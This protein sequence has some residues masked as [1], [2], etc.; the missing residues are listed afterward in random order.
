MCLLNND[1]NEK[2][3]IFQGTATMMVTPFADGRLWDEAFREL[4]EFQVDA[5]VQAIVVAGTAGEGPGMDDSLRKQVIET[6]ISLAKKRVKVI[7]AAG[8]PDTAYTEELVKWACGKGA[9]G[10]LV[11]P[12]YYAK[13]SETGLY[14]Y[15]VDVADASSVPIVLSNIP[16]RTGI[17][18]SVEL[19][20]HLA[21]HPM[22][23]GVKDVSGST[24]FSGEVMR[25]CRGKMHLWTG[26]DDQIVPL[27]AMGA[28]GVFST[29]A[30]LIPVQI[31]EMADQ[32]LW[33]SVEEKRAAADRQIE[34]MGFFQSQFW[35]T[36]P[37]PIKTAMGKAGFPVG[38]FRPP[39]V[40][41]G[42]AV[43]EKMQEAIQDIEVD[44]FWK[45]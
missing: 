25:R 28:K 35:E 18:L 10:F 21:G 17:S 33:G 36:H 31:R 11:I 30:N 29:A 43:W 34:Y 12:P 45:R 5:G 40:E 4:I 41:M 23:N 27:L 1:K 26:N 7:V 9:D 8:G 22:I 15:Y 13:T 44:I 19:C 6:A 20:E 2:T 32:M 38:E 16:A 37:I 42:E 24:V 39:L 14:R 3:P